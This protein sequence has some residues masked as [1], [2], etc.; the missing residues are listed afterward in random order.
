MCSE[1]YVHRFCPNSLQCQLTLKIRNDSTVHER[2]DI[3]GW[4]SRNDG[5]VHEREDIYGRESRDGSRDDVAI[6][7]REDI[8]GREMMAEWE[9]N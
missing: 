1:V 2:K 5:A 8:Y 7:E 9:V 3:Y 4:E 6:H